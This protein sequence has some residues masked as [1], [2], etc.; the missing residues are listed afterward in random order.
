[1]TYL[2]RHGT[3]RVPQS[4]PLPGQAAEQRRRLRLGGRR[5]GAAAPLP[6]PR[7][8]GRQLLRVAS[9][10]SRAR[11]REAV[12]RCLARGRRA[13]GRRDRRASARRA[14]RRRTTRRS[15]RSRWRR[16][17]ATRRRA[18]RRSRRCRRCARTGTHLFQFATFVEG[19]RG[20]GRA[21]RRAV[22]ALVRRRAG[23]RARL[24]GGQVPPARGRD[25]PRPAAPGAPGGPGRAPATRRSTSRTSTRRLFEWIVRGGDDRRPA[26]HRRGLRARAGGDDAGARRRSSSA[27][28]ACRARR[29]R[30]GAP[31]LARGLGG[32]ARG[33]ADDGARPQPGDD[34]ARRRA[35]AG[36]GRH[37]AG[38]RAAR[39]RGAHPRGARA[40][41]RACWRRCA[42]TRPAAACAAAATWTPVR[43][44]VDALDAAFYTAFG[45]VEPT[46]KRL[47][48][49]LDVSGSMACGARRRRAGPDAARR[50]GGARARHGGDGDA[51]RD[52]RLLRRRGG[53]K[54]GR[55]G[56]GLGYTD[57]LTPLAISPRQR[58]DDAVQGRVGPA[59][60]R[61]GLR[62]ADAVRARRKERRSTR[63]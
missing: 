51:V 61:H 56:R 12:E 36:L 19:F 13:R 53:W 23:G 46:G 34:D 21:L 60:R 11:T 10:R 49:A 14:A 7:L 44:V 22:G 17:P 3:R 45:N 47:L 62:A 28:T 8:R 31:D 24:P 6:D 54:P 40:P 48:L 39:R 4:A 55:R 20:W 35:R 33:H 59:V 27:S 2:K 42:R 41:D 25:A 43:E 38:G 58:L 9:G 52:R 57:G 16:A 37:G 1:M 63:S 50:L 18:R 15:S 26:A 29:C 30:A 5:L 32:A